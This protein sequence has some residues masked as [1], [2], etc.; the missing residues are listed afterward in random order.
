MREMSR[1]ETPWSCGLDM[2][3]RREGPPEGP[4]CWPS[5]QGRAAWL[6]LGWN[7]GEQA[8]RR[9]EGLQG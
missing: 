1:S 7:L 6:G 5:G 2:T 3:V 9:R 8:G 4:C